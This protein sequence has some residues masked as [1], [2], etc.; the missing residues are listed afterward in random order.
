MHMPSRTVTIH[1]NTTAELRGLNNLITKIEQ[2]QKMLNGFGKGVDK[3]ASF[4]NSIDKI[5]KSVERL[6]S[7]G[8]SNPLGRLNTNLTNMNETIQKMGRGVKAFDTVARGVS[9]LAGAA[10]KLDTLKSVN[11]DNMASGLQNI[12]NATRTFQ[13]NFNNIATTATKVATNTNTV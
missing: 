5:S 3:F 7:V 13:T 10:Q 8:R 6:S 1:I 9:T 12:S 4:S 11:F 2:S